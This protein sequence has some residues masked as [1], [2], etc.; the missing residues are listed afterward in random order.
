VF[1]F[2]HEPSLLLLLVDAAGLVPV[3]GHQKK[4][5]YV[6]VVFIRLSSCMR[7]VFCQSSAILRVIGRM[8]K[9]M[10]TSDD[11]LYQLDKV[12]VVLHESSNLNY[13]RLNCAKVLML[14]TELN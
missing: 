3:I 9:L 13:S 7:Q 12:G 11:D 2:L 14:E 5:V 1:V 6:D 10:P 8:G 4:A